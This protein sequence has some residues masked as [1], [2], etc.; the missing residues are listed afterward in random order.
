[1]ATEQSNGTASVA[2]RVDIGDSEFEIVDPGALTGGGPGGSD[3]SGD[4]GGNSDAGTGDGNDFV[5]DPDRHIGADKRNADGSFRRKRRR[6]GSG[7]ASGTGSS[8]RG[9]KKETN[10][11]VSGLEQLLFSLHLSAAAITKSP[12]FALTP[13][14][15]NNLAKAGIEVAKLYPQLNIAPEIVAWANLAMVAGAV[16]VPRAIA[17]SNRLTKERM[18]NVTPENAPPQHYT[19]AA[20]LPEATSANAGPVPPTQPNAG[21]GTSI[22]PDFFQ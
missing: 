6:G 13:A 21:P 2:G 4:G 12:E 18:K 14:E 22:G 7:G 3:G 5:F 17:V 16:Y 9:S 15:A 11:S 19:P 20:V 1:M 8:R 10:Y